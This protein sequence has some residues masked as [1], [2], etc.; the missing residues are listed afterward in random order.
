MLKEF[1]KDTKPFGQLVTLFVLVVFFIIFTAGLTAGSVF[2]GFDTS[3]LH[4]LLFMQLVTQV[5]VFLVPV[6]IAMSLFSDSPSVSLQLDFSR[7]KWLLALVG[8]LLLV[9]LIPFS[10]W[11]TQLNDSWHWSGRWAVFEEKMRESTSRNEALVE[12]FLSQQGV[13]NLMLNLL[14][15]ALVPAVCEEFFFRGGVQT[16]MCR[17]VRNPHV[18]IFISAAIFSLLHGE[19]FAF[20]PRF[21][22]G[23]LLGY[24]FYYGGSM[25]I[26]MTVHF[27]NNAIIVIVQYFCA[28]GSLSESWIDNIEAPWFV[29]VGG[30]L[31][32]AILFYVFFLRRKN[33]KQISEPDKTE[34][35]KA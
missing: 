9:L 4:H 15:V 29:L 34:P 11:L 23:A 8:L 21:F 10:D 1:F 28:K 19:F 16:I 26:N 35:F 20:L 7:R 22:L 33:E 13:G 31:L 25:L 6:W 32:S 17:W 27:F 3:N 24:L 2:L 30:M 14:V 18:A 5:L 12:Q